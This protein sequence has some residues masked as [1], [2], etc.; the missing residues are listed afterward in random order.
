M[1]SIGSAKPLDRNADDMRYRQN[2]TK[3]TEDQTPTASAF[4]IR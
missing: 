3:E 4:P 1:S 2:A